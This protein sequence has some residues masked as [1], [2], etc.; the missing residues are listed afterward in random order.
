[1]R[2]N[3]AWLRISRLDT[4]VVGV[5]I[6][7]VV[8]TL[9]MTFLGRA[10]AAGQRVAFLKN[11]PG[12]IANVWIAD[13][14]NPADAKQITF[15]AD[16]V[17]DFG[18]SPDGRSIAF[19]ER[20][21]ESNSQE[22]KLLDLRTGRI[23]QLTDCM[24]QDSACTTPVWRPDG[25]LIAYQR[26]EFNSA[27]NIGASPDR[28]WL[29]DLSTTPA[30]T[31]PLVEDSQVLG[32][33]PEW[34]A[35]GQRLAFYDNGSGGILIYNFAADTAADEN[36]FSYV[37]TANGTVGSFSPDGSKL[38]YPEM[39]INGAPVVHSYLQLADLDNGLSQDL[40]NPEDQA[41]DQAV[42]WNP[43]G[44]TIAIGR[45]YLDDRYTRGHQIYLY[46]TTD[47]T[48]EPLI[49]DEAYNHGY[50]EWN[51]AGD[52]L[53]IQRFRFPTESGEDVGG[54]QIW[55]YNITTRALT[56]I[57]DDAYIPRWVP[58]EK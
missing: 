46:D 10:D 42:Q 34:S 22:I 11:S 55:T 27:L 24:A 33:Y 20:D 13:A 36:P 8:A 40:T 26:I 32:Y 57:I 44:R 1:V 14:D 41:D 58:A 47:G 28:I 43:N 48:M 56:L 9:L 5:S 2:Q 6:L 12:G 17:F 23:T 30:T 39:L 37:T 51:P 16:G 45:R 49:Y 18:V 4:V 31:Y 54:T 50:F 21:F 7:L 53:V 29:L 35:N 38:V 52:E 25:Q 3:R 15:A 19:S